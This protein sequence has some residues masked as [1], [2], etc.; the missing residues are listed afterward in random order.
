MIIIKDNFKYIYNKKERSEEFYDL[1]VD[2]FETVNLLTENW[3]S[4]KRQ[5]TFP[6]DKIYSYPK[7]NEAKEAYSELKKEKER[8]WREGKFL[9]Y[10]FLFVQSLFNINYYFF[11]RKI[12]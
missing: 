7:W 11:L 10:N 5:V 8:I 2:P 6:L 3:Y 12:I 9:E 4:A 1:S